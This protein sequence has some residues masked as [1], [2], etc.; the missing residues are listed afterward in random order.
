MMP[1]ASSVSQPS[2]LH[3]AL[4]AIEVLESRL[5][6]QRRSTTE[7]IAITGI[8]C[9]FPGGSNSPAEYWDL[10]SQG[11]DAV[12]V[13]P[14]Q[15]WDADAF[16]ATHPD[17]PGRMLTRHGG[18]LDDIESFD[19]AFFGISPREAARMDPQHRLLLEVAWESLDAAGQ[20]P[21][22]RAGRN[23]GVFVG[24][25][26][27]E[28]GSLQLAAEGT[29][30]LD[31]YHLTGNALNT[32][33]G[34][35]AFVFG[36]QG[37]ALA[38]DTACSSSLTAVH[39]ACQSLRRRECDS[40]L[41]LGVNALLSPVG[42][43]ALSR[44][45]VLAPSGRARTFDEQA[46]GMVRGEGCGAVVLKR[47][48]DAIRDGDPILAVI[49]G[50][51]I[52]QD[53]PSSGLTVPHRPAQE[54]LL[55]DAL[56]EA[57]LQPEA[58]DYIETHGTG[59]PLGDPIEVGALGDV[60]AADRTENNP[61]LLGSVKTNFGHLES[62]AGIAGLIK[63]ILALHHE[64]LPP[65]LHFTEPSSKI[66]W[67][68]GR[69]RVTDSLTT[70]PRQN[71]PRI[72]GVSSFGFS[73]T[74]AHIILAEAPLSAGKSLT[75]KPRELSGPPPDYQRQ[76]FPLPPPQLPD[77]GWAFDLPG[78]LIKLPNAAEQ[79]FEITLHAGLPT[80]IRDHRVFG[81]MVFP[82]AG[83][84]ELA[85]RA[86]QLGGLPALREGRILRALVIPDH[87]PVTL[88]TIVSPDGTVEVFSRSGEQ[89]E[90]IQHFTGTV[91]ASPEAVPAADA[92]TDVTDLPAVSV[93][94]LYQNYRDRGLDY[95]PSFSGLISLHAEPG[96]A[97]AEVQLPPGAPLSAH[98]GA[99]SPALLDACFQAAGAAFAAPDN[100]EA[101]YLPVAA[102]G[103]YLAG[104]DHDFGAPL[105]LVAQTSTAS[106]TATVSLQILD[107]NDQVIARLDH[108]ELQRATAKA[109]AQQLEPTAPTDW[110]Y[111]VT[112]VPQ[113]LAPM[114]GSPQLAGNWLIVDPASSHGTHLAETLRQA[115]GNPTVAPK[116]VSGT[117][118]GV[119]VLAGFAID[120]MDPDIAAATTPLLRT[121]QT[122]GTETNHSDLWIVTP[123]PL[124]RPSTAA[125]WG[126]G[127]VIQA[128]WNHLVS[129]MVGLDSFDPKPVLAELGQPTR[130]NQIIYRKQSRHALRLQPLPPAARTPIS[131]SAERTYLVTGGRGALGMLSA[132]WLVEN[133]ARYLALI[134]RRPPTEENRQSIAVW[135]AAGIQVEL[136]ELDLTDAAAVRST[137]AKLDQSFPPLAGVIHAAGTIQDATL[138]DQTAQHFEQTAAA[139]SQA[140][141]NL[142]RAITDHKYQLDFWINY[143]SSAGV[144]GTPGQANYAA[145]NAWLDAFITPADRTLNVAWGPWTAGLGA[146]IGDRYTARG[147]SSIKPAQAFALLETR[148][149]GEPKAIAVLPINWSRFFAANFSAGN[150]P[151]LDLV[152][153]SDSP[154][155]PISP[156]SSTALETA[157]LPKVIRQQI[158]RVL[159]LDPARLDDE[160]TLPLQG[161]DSLMAMELRH[162]LQKTTG[163]DIPVV[164]FLGDTPVGQLITSVA[165]QKPPQ[166]EPET[167]SSTGTELSRGQSALWFLHQSDPASAAYHT[168]FALR[169]RGPIDAPKLQNIFTQLVSR[170][171]QLRA[172]FPRDAGTPI[173][174]VETESVFPFE[175]GDATALTP[176]QLAAKVAR[177]YAQPFDLEQ[178]SLL[179]VNLYQQSNREEA[180]LL[181][182]IHHI[183]SDAWTNW[184]LLDEFRRLYS[185]TEPLP[186]L[187]A[188][189]HDFVRWQKRFLASPKAGEAWAFWQR[190]LAGPLPVS[191][192]PLDFDRPVSLAARGA[193]VPL[194]FSPELFSR[195]KTLAQSEGTTVFTLLLT[196]WQV[197]LHR[198]TGQNDIIV[199][200]PTAGRSQAEFTSVAG[201]FVNPVPFR[202]QLDPTQPFTALLANN[203]SHHLAVLEHADYPLPLLVEKLKVRRDPARPAIFQNLFVYQKPQQGETGPRPG[204]QSCGD[205]QIEEFPLAQMEGQFELTLEIFAG[206]TGT[207]KY[208]T[209]LFSATS[210]QRFGQRFGTLLESITT[211][212]NQAVA[213]LPLL[214]AAEHEL[215]TQTWQPVEPAYSSETTLVDL[216]LR[217]AEK[218]GDAPA[219]R[220]GQTTLTYAELY[221]RAHS[222][223][224][225]LQAEGVGPDVLVGVCA[226]RSPDLVIALLG[227]MLAGG[228]YVPFDPF[229]PEER[230][231]FMHAD[232]GVA[233]VLTTSQFAEAWQARAESV[234]VL[235]Q[236]LPSTT[237]PYVAPALTPDHAAY[238]IYTS[239][240]T[241][242]PKGALNIH[243]AIVNRLQWMQEEYSIDDTDTILQKTPFSFD[244][245]VWEFFWP[246]LNGA[247]LVLAQPGGHQDPT[248]L[249]D[250]IREENVTHLHFVPSMLQLFVDVPGLAECASLRRIICSG[251][252]LPA[253]LPARLFSR[254]PRVE[255]HNL[256]GPTE[257]AVD[258]SY[259]V[260]HRDAPAGP[261]PIGRPVDRTQLYVLNEQR[262]PQPIGVAGELHI[263]GVQLMRGYHHR[264][265][266]N[267]EKLVADPFSKV[268][269]AR[270]Y[271]TGDLVSWRADGVLEYHGRIDGQIKLRGFRIEL[272]E[273]ESALITL[274]E[275]REAAVIL[276]PDHA[277]DPQLVAYL[278]PT[279]AAIDTSD[280]RR[281]LRKLLPE[282]MVPAVFVTLTS[283]PLSPN[284]KLDRKALPAPPTAPD[285]TTPLSVASA[286]ETLLHTHW[287]DLLGHSNFGPED[288]FFDLGGHS[289]HLGRLHAQL[290]S[291][292]HADLT[293]VELFQYPTIRTLAQR[294]EGATAA[295]VP[296]SSG[297]EKTPSRRGSLSQQRARR[298]EA[299]DR[300]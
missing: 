26:G 188:G 45:Q 99:P 42:S 14:P 58:I 147:V 220:F 203:R 61:L 4:H 13:V 173:C 92:I 34:R 151:L 267:A 27:A 6:D 229:Y 21:D 38:V 297:A 157:D 109:L 9:R 213:Q 121:A 101:V 172:R 139:K 122:W 110:L 206:G 29:H 40:A 67:Q 212:P 264:P 144:L 182:T 155:A 174:L 105:K 36:L 216:L 86:G 23:T 103:W 236:G 181:C 82:A 243:R 94:H 237:A 112:P 211:N 239:G 288:N 198:H 187:A 244:V 268:T 169:L 3:R 295:P 8:G 238:L 114:A 107:Q 153:P 125:L 127:R 97:I 129:R 138:A 106:E 19:P 171:P 248:Y 290:Q 294:L 50:S 234:W 70:W 215:V 128:E 83:W 280:L 219:V 209:A 281:E 77:T 162:A 276:R 48:S 231:E 87:A 232:S 20:T 298:R 196:A 254:H 78:K 242:R 71:R 228:A 59:T 195:L 43:I 74:N 186:Q 152:R 191:M 189:Y 46:D 255:L 135:Q 177:D 158:A 69:L 197:W 277:N 16:L 116:F 235:D 273:I 205:L 192:L 296:N 214:P 185:S 113:S 299:R 282:H 283:W 51:A 163:V 73:G 89:A 35:L 2:P 53:G 293:L 246:L 22:R 39:L 256:Y 289:L 247:R 201:Y 204:G 285:S 286:A 72:A 180:V 269:A 184:L 223:A 271:R 266:L 260:C 179:R 117:W 28:Y 258:V 241:G 44:G 200:S 284:G 17:T 141:S 130:E 178:D 33:A 194:N 183:V 252:A 207:L 49:R 245:S 166:A 18:F 136:P 24:I 93:E 257:A 146:A 226:E 160:Q 190:T 250:L 279:G 131:L 98:E 165:E 95:G 278:I 253:D 137:I 65:H 300:S 81:R 240:S 76:R 56:T 102:S 227:T 47:V 249:R 142:T 221:A 222:L 149:A 217:Q 7:A 156:P 262:E 126:L 104:V 54:R 275:I 161:L 176:S 96:S 57:G 164:T 31:T 287:T 115:G 230:L 41:A 12:T 52:N 170:H 291:G 175:I 64:A 25:T 218:S 150:P 10:L 108:L 11:R 133:G 63:T 274:P 251:E 270:L 132:A 66:D 292:G 225:A 233:L 120:P 145:A 30:S 75:P 79:H 91:A 85:R 199:G 263:G 84:F 68:Q 111:E 118:S 210:A 259:W 202:A 88:H 119:I 193:S 167:A 159:R 37:P 55:R 124:E 224:T 272:G 60:F 15:R 80:W 148:L 134:G 143:S 154:T 168:A 62:A 261:I 265:E 208:N 140:A 1:T 100:A 90:W 5:E 123:S 32:A